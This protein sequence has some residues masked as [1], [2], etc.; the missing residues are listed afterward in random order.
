VTILYGKVSDKNGIYAV[1]YIILMNVHIVSI[2]PVLNKLIATLNPTVIAIEINT[3]LP[4]AATAAASAGSMYCLAYNGLDSGK[5]SYF[6]DEFL[7]SN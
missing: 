7:G 2:D 6:E 3:P 5:Y 1:T 4:A